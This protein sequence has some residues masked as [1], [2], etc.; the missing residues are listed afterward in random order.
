MGSRSAIDNDI[1]LKLSYF[2]LLDAFSALL[3]E[4]GGGGVLGAARYVVRSYIAKNSNVEN[5][6]DVVR[7]FEDFLVTV[8]EFEPTVAEVELAAELEKAAA[9]H[10][11]EL[12][13]G[14]SQLCAILVSRA[15]DVLLTGDKRAIAALAT[16]GTTNATVAAINGRLACLE[17]L[18]IRVTEDLGA[19]SVRLAVCGAKFADRAMSICFSCSS[20]EVDTASIPEALASY[21]GSVRQQ[22]GGLLVANL[23]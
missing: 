12:D 8:E 9:R 16:L 1:L 14:E 18:M 4:N 11:V 7:T 19:D 6:S 17:Q 23:W 3:A 21:V 22:S 20:P 15:L 5:P 2:S 13:P 10:L